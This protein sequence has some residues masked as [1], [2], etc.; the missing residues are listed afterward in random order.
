MSQIL[1]WLKNTIE[2][3]PV[4]YSRWIFRFTL[5]LG[6]SFGCKHADLLEESKH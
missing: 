3:H 1:E 4:T 2:T 5:P 6:G